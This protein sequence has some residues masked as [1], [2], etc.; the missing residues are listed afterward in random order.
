MILSLHISNIALIEDLTLNFSKGLHVM[1]GETGAGKSIVVDAVNL[2]LGGRGD[3]DLIRTG[4]GKASVEAVFD[5]SGDV[6]VMDYLTGQE[7]T[8]EDGQ[9]TLYREITSSGRNVCRVCGVLTPLAVLRETASLLMDVHGQHEG[10]FLMDPRYHLGFLDESGDEQHARLMEETQKACQEFLDIHR[11]YARLARE[12][13]RKQ[14]RM[15]TLKKSLDEIRKAR[16]KPGEDAEL[17]REQQKLRHNGKIIHAV[18]TAHG[19]LSAGEEASALTQLKGAMDALGGI[20]EL[21][22]KYASLS[23]RISSAYYELEEAGYEIASMLET[24]EFDPRRAQQVDQKLDLIRHLKK[25]YGETIEAILE[26]AG[27]MQEE[28]DALASLDEQLEA[29]TQQHRKLLAAYRQKARELSASRHALAE[30]FEKNMR[31]QLADLGMEKTVFSV[32]FA[33]PP[34]RQQLPQPLGEDAV[35]F[36][37]SANPG[38]PLKGLSKIASGGELSRIMLAL[39]SLEAERGGVGC[40]VFDE[41]DTGISG[42]MAQVV[43]E[44]MSLIARSRQ[45]ICVT[46]LP[47][48]AAMADHEFLVE[49]HEENGRTNTSVHLLT[50]EERIHEVGRMI[51]GTD[52]TDTSAQAHAAHMLS[53]AAN[54]RAVRDGIAPQSAN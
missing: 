51:S 12:N 10:R 2:V 50:D 14:F 26:K 45:V 49:K 13:E 29:V 54:F 16:L 24:N 17:E 40:M 41:I 22:P 3:R 8:V 46:H 15:E 32:S 36:M 18:R 6:E 30:A 33:P 27:Q 38:E 28:Y 25:T 9:V 37:L 35:E 23:E 11:Q 47:Q 21:D 7:I 53:S 44:K 39:K 31:G 5:V 4:K 43:A 48:I 42:R 19:C 34:A 1:T 20:A 52:G